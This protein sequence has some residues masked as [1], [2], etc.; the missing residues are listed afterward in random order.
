MHDN[1]MVDM[2]HDKGLSKHNLARLRHSTQPMF[3]ILLVA[4][5]A[6]AGVLLLCA[7]CCIHPM[8]APGP[9]AHQ[10]HQVRSS[11]GTGASFML[12]TVVSAALYCPQPPHEL[13]GSP[14][15]ITF[16]E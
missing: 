1:F 15:V 5:D 13:L 7:I 16:H 6:A 9:V 14:L 2:A 3:D 10:E 4:S 11:F 12:D 8:G